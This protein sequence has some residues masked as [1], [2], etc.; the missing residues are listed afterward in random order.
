M[1]NL[2]L[3][4]KILM[5]LLLPIV[6]ILILSFNSIYDKYEKNIK[7]NEK[8][9]YLNFLEKVSLLTHDLQKEREIATL[10]LDSYGKNY[11]DDL[12]KQ[13]KKSNESIDNFNNI[14]KFR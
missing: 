8:L 4:N 3:Q 5:I 6:T 11:L 14:I 1:N 7:M 10:F 12:N 9:N 13:T 2:K